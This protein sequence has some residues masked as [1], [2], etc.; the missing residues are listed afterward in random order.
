MWADGVM[1]LA[2]VTSLEELPCAIPKRIR[3]NIK[4]C[5]TINWVEQFDVDAYHVADLNIVVIGKG[6]LMAAIQA[7][8][9]RRPKRLLEIQAVVEKMILEYRTWKNK[10]LKHLWPPSSL[11]CPDCGSSL[12]LR[13][14]LVCSNDSHHTV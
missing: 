6:S 4:M 1:A 9:I 5:N 8:Q 14:E 7:M 2:D 13:A 10:S 3:Y 11:R 12:H